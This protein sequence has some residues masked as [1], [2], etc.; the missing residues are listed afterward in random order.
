VKPINDHDAA[1]EKCC[2][3]NEIEHSLHDADFRA[4]LGLFDFDARGEGVFKFIQMCDDEYFLKIVFDHIDR[5]DQS[6][7]SL[8]ILRA[9]ALI[10]N[11]CLQAREAL[12]HDNQSVAYRFPVL[13]SVTFGLLHGL[14]FA[15]ALGETGLP[16]REIP[17]ALLFFNIGVEIGQLAFIAAVL[18]LVAI[19]R[20]LL[21]AG[22]VIAW[23]DRY[24]RIA[25]SYLIGVPAAFWLLQRL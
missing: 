15:A 14:G 1:N 20:R 9:E 21:A 22:G 10:D 17:L 13:V 7:P 8:S 6:L 11:K 19:G 5:F 12:V 4:P 23:A 24:G 2:G 18:A 25:A 16:D 3:K